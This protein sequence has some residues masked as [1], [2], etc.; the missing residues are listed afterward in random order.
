MTSHAH[1]TQAATLQP[2]GKLPRCPPAKSVRGKRRTRL[3]GPA[4]TA[5]PRRR[6]RAAGCGPVALTGSTSKARHHSRGHRTAPHPGRPCGQHYL[7]PTRSPRTARLP[8]RLWRHGHPSARIRLHH[9]TLPAPRDPALNGLPTALPR[10]TWP[11]QLWGS[12]VDLGGTAR[13]ESPLPGSLRRSEDT[14]TWLP[15]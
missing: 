4:A 13:H 6:V 1:L 11:S 14:S 12:C 7:S 2:C 3:T 15:R 8:G 9:N 5:S 10:P